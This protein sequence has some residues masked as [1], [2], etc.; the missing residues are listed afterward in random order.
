MDIR[1]SSLVDKK[2]QSLILSSCLYDLAYGERTDATFVSRQ[3]IMMSEL[4]AG[5]FIF[6]LNLNWSRDMASLIASQLRC[7]ILPGALTPIGC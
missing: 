2:Y 6:R 5:N 4:I 1:N 3:I 7:E